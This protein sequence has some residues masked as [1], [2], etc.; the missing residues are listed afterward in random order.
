MADGLFWV[1]CFLM[2]RGAYNKKLTAA[3]RRIFDSLKSEGVQ[4]QGVKHRKLISEFFNRNDLQRPIEIRWQDYIIALYEAGELPEIVP[5]KRIPKSEKQKAVSE[6]RQRY[7]DY[8]NSPEWK[9]FRLKALDHFGNK[10]GL[11]DSD[12]RLDLH[13]KTYKN[14]MKETFADVIPLCRKCHNRHHNR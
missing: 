10:C 2:N 9:S 1:S 7:E 6:R 5:K 13:H 14:F 4:I 12:G 3:K 8:L 11:C